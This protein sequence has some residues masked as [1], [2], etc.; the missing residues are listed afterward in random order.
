MRIEGDQDESI[1]LFKNVALKVIAF[2][3]DAD[4]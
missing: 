1:N 3:W 4:C 2:I